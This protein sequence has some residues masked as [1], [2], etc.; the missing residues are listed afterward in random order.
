MNRTPVTSSNIKSIGYD[1]STNVLEVEFSS[2]TV[3]QY[4]D[5]PAQVYKD[6]SEADSVGRYFAA[7]VRNVFAAHRMPDKK[8]EQSEG[9]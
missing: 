5:V 2:G 9:E 1:P 8:P 4:A 7:N 3:Y 6:M